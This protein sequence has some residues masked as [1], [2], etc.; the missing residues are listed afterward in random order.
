[1][2]Y[3]NDS[4]WVYSFRTKQVGDVLF[5]DGI[6]LPISWVLDRSWMRGARQWRVQGPTTLSDTW[7]KPGLPTPRRLI[8]CWS[9]TKLRAHS[10]G[11]ESAIMHSQARKL[12]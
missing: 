2:V 5:A 12:S 6:S 7:P 10:A 9:S 3:I 4:D 8:L 11:I 1:M